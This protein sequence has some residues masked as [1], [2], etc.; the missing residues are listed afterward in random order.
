M[1][2]TPPALN[3]LITSDSGYA[4]MVA[5]LLASVRQHLPKEMDLE[6]YWLHVDGS[7]PAREQLARFCEESL[8]RCRLHISS[9]DTL[10][11]DI[12]AQVEALIGSNDSSW[13]PA[14]C[15][16]AP[17]ILPL[18]LPESVKRA[19]FVDADVIA[20]GDISELTTIPL[21]GFP[22]GFVRAPL[23]HF[24]KRLGLERYGN[25]GLIVVDVDAW[26]EAEVSKG[27]IDYLH[28]ISGAWSANYPDQDA[29][30]HTLADANGNAKWKEL[31]PKWNACAPLFTH[32][33]WR[34]QYD[35]IDIGEVKLLHYCGA[36]PWAKVPATLL[37]R[38]ARKKGIRFG[39]TKPAHPH[40]DLFYDVLARTPFSAPR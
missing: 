39:P 16:A 20:L 24:N 5:C 23:K 30:N 10:P 12:K 6:V 9:L 27:A 36:K 15:F 19:I 28:K 18:I 2:P 26:K 22:A 1:N 21:D 17:F 14:L 11:A 25:S 4:P 40:S 35:P 13:G 8:E 33:R 31:H 3:L 34:L 7:V 38:I 29:L 37:G 32:P